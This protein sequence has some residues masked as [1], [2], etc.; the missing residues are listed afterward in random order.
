MRKGKKIHD[1]KYNFDPGRLNHK[2]EFFNLVTTNDGFGGV[3]VAKQSVLATKCGRLPVRLEAISQAQQLGIISGVS[4]FSDSWYFTVRIRK[5]FTPKKDMVVVIDGGEEYT[6]HGV[7]LMDDHA[8]YWRL[9]CSNS[10]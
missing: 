2:I 6:L 10:K 3:T 4:D 8:T 9:L 1:N 7:Q 5:G